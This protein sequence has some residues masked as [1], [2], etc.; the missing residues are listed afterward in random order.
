[1][2]IEVLAN[3]PSRMDL[4][5]QIRLVPQPAR[6]MVGVRVLLVDDDPADSSLVMDILKRHP[7]VSMAR[8]TDSPTFALREI[9]SGR[10]TADLILLDI[11]MPR[12][13]GFEFLEQIRELPHMAQVPVVFLTTSRLRRDVAKAKRS[14]ASMYLVKPD[15]YF[16]LQAGLN[17]VIRRAALGRWPN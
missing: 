7:R 6:S 15:E 9:E 12:M 5:P 4:S 2:S 1:M 16:D 14:S 10:L 17:G 11:H 3:P 13:D 8:A